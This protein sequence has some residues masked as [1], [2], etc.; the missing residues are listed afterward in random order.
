MSIH[1]KGYESRGKTIEPKTTFVGLTLCEREENYYDDSDGYSHVYDTDTHSIDRYGTWTTRA[2][3][4]TQPGIVDAYEDDNPWKDEMRQAHIDRLVK[5]WFMAQETEYRHQYH[6]ASI[7]E[8]G[9]YVIVVRGRK[10]V[11]GTEGVIFWMK[12]DEYSYNYHSK[13]CD[14]QR[15][16]IKD[17]MGEVHWTTDNNVVVMDPDLPDIADYIGETEYRAELAELTL[18]QLHGMLCSK[19]S[20]L[21][22]FG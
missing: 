9:D 14:K 2:C 18:R 15:I 12:D 3:S 16:G 11:K 21:A 13:E 4:M 22:H 19:S 5:F 1:T 20:R 10:V 8:K 7:V 17:D 6:A